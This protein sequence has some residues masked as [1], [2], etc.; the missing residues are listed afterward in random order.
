MTGPPGKRTYEESTEPEQPGPGSKA[1]GAMGGV[2]MMNPKSGAGGKNVPWGKQP[3]TGPAFQNS[4]NSWSQPGSDD[5]NMDSQEDGGWQNDWQQ[6]GND[7]WQDQN[8]SWGTAPK[9]SDSQ[10]NGWDDSTSGMQTSW[11][12]SPS[13]GSASDIGKGTSPSPSPSPAT[14][15]LK[16]GKA[17]EEW[18]P[19]M[20]GGDASFLVESFELTVDQIMSEYNL[21]PPSRRSGVLNTLARRLTEELPKDMLAE[22]ADK[23]TGKVG[24]DS[25]KAEEEAKTATPKGATFGA[26]PGTP[27]TKPW[28]SDDSGTG[29]KAASAPRAPWAR[30]NQQT[31][32]GAKPSSPPPAATPP[33]NPWSR[34]RSAT[35]MTPP[36]ETTAQD[37][38]SSSSN[39]GNDSEGA[40]K[41]SAPKATAGKGALKGGK[42][43][44]K[45]GGV[46][47][48]FGAQ[49]DAQEDAEDGGWDSNSKGWGAKG[50][51]FGKGFQAQE[52]QTDT[53]GKGTGKSWGKASPQEEQPEKGKGAGKPWGNKSAQ[54]EN[55]SWGS[56]AMQSWESEDSSAPKGAPKYGGAQK[57][58]EEEAKAPSKSGFPG[59][60]AGKN[61]PWGPKA[62]AAKLPSP[63]GAKPPGGSVPTPG[64][65]VPGSKA[66]AME[67]SIKAAPKWAGGR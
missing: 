37:D 65:S 40:P 55:D 11:G 67:S 28:A 2:G 10:S 48:F 46:S 23:I 26:K 43:M 51:S 8:S 38:W 30:Q 41:S 17:E 33:K 54:Q 15:G 29:P 18:N 3:S 22:L 1:K 16:G 25:K 12:T 4:Y 61:P 39:W 47:A 27:P 13:G 35:K 19:E 66:A 42:N 9:G 52:E 6:K 60:A 62:G 49:D 57:S 21:L 59:S 50:K 36:E 7:N 14:G 63:P 34:D 56:Q 20:E 44:G 24:P 64:A 53:K 32:G 5:M 58:W 45:V 31:P